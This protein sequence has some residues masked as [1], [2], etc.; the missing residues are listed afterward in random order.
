MTVQE[1]LALLSDDVDIRRRMACDPY[2]MAYPALLTHF[3]ALPSLTWDAAVVGLHIVYAWM[4]TI[5][6]LAGMQWEEAK[7]E[8]LSATLNA[9]RSGKDP[10]VE[11]LNLL[12]DF[13]NNSIIG[14]SKL[15]H[16]L[17][18]DSFP[19]WDTRVAKVFL[20][21]SKVGG[22]QVNQVNRWIEYRTTLISW[23]T[24]DEVRKNC[25]KLRQDARFL[26]GVSDLRLLELVMFHQTASRRKQ[27][28]PSANPDGLGVSGS[29]R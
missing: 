9:A 28:K 23:L 24:N 17:K 21:N 5:P 20:K 27:G 25:C 4:P 1:W 2:A 13:C 29:M 18:P 10:S 11:D 15:L 7:R 6:R 3:A 12:K 14:A 16:F 19:I 22:A 8:K 26:S